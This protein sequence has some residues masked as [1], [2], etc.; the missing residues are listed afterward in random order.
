MRLRLDDSG[1]IPDLCDHY[2]R[3]GFAAQPVSGSLVEIR[4]ADAP[5]PG[6]ERREILLHLR[7]WMAMNPVADVTVV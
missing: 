4:R 3:A 1:L 5:D 6:Q 7:V 2:N